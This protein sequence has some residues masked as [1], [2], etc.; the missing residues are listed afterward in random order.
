MAD[1]AA[2]EYAYAL[3][4]RDVRQSTYQLA[5]RELDLKHGVD[6]NTHKT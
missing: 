4:L 5:C 3:L 1:A 6:S 2:V